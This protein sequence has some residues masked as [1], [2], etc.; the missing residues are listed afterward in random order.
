MQR[1]RFILSFSTY[2]EKISIEYIKTYTVYLCYQNFTV[3]APKK[4]LKRLCGQ[5]KEGQHEK[6]TMI[7]K[8][9]LNPFGEC[10]MKNK[11]KSRKQE[12]TFR[13]WKP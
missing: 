6:K 8:C 5:K 4:Y 1:V 13:K 7:E 2:R 9:C 3:G 10:K 11:N 12:G